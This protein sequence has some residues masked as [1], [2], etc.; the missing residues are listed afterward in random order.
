MNKPYVICHMVASIDGRTSTSAWS[1]SPEGRTEYERTAATY[2][3]D[4]WMCGRTTMA[5]Y[6][7][8]AAPVM[9]VPP[10]GLAKRDFLAPHTHRAFAAHR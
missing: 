7:R 2:K 5:G 3:A 1:L 9:P 4:T 10:S 8:E 6:A